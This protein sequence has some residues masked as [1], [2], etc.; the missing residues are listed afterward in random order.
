MM[1]EGR[2]IVVVVMELSG[3]TLIRSG[4]RTAVQQRIISGTDEMCHAGEG[5]YESDS[6]LE[7]C[8]G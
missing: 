3:H 4:N 6:G 7:R 5:Y 8:K 1:I 2:P